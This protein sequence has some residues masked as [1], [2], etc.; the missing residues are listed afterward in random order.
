M[1]FCL[2]ITTVLAQVA[3]INIET[4]YSNGLSNNQVDDFDVNTDGTILNNS[5]SGGTSQL[6][7][8]AVTANTNI[9]A[10]SEA[11]LILFQVTTT[12]ASSLNGQIE[13]F[14][15]EAGVII[16]NPNGITCDGC[17]FINTG[18]VDLV[19]GTAN[20]SGDDLTSFSI[21]DAARL[22][23]SGNGF[24]SDAV[25]DELNLV[26]RTL[27]IKA[28]VK[29]NTTLRILA[30]NDTYDHTTNI[31]TSDT[32]EATAHSIQINASGSLEANYIELINTE[33]SSSGIYGI[34]NYGRDISADSLKLDSNGLFRNQDGGG[35]V[36]N[37][38]ISSLLEVINAERF[39]NNGNITADTLT[40]T[41]DEFSNNHNG[42]TQLGKI[43][44]TD[45][46]SLST[47]NASYTNTG[48]VATDS[49]NLTTSGNFDH[50]SGILGNFTFNNLSII[51]DNYTQGVTIDIAGD[52]SIQVSGEASLD[53]NASIKANN[54][55]FSAYDLYNQADF[56]ITGNTT[57]MVKITT[58]CKV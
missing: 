23:V 8:T 32:T 5:A 16:A 48:T 29:A 21:Y 36:G 12:S 17:G 27:I 39:I 38:N 9:S 26:S 35:N 57:L 20:F 47:P 56:T 43:V 44:V 4:P 18:K 15:S 45:I 41:T 1:F 42:N 3:T 54:L 30:G 50:E 25:A 31:I 19:T 22:I 34:V 37:I 49:L 7:N 11:N 40:I 53:D 52:I 51:A 33:I 10:G 2:A 6:G 28:Q 24:V 14:G 13:V 55:F 46:F 58:G